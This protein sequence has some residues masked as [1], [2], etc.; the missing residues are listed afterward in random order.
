M[1]TKFTKFAAAAMAVVMAFA[2]AACGGGSNGGGSSEGGDNVLKLGGVGP[3]TGPAALYGQAVEKG[4]KLAVEEINAANPDGVQLSFDMQDDEH[5]AEKAINAYNKLVDDGMQ[6]L[7][8]TVT[9]TPCT[10]V[11]TEADANRTFALTPSASAPDVTEGHDNVFQLC[12]SD[13]NQGVASAQY[14]LGNF[15]DA[16]VGVIYNNSD[17]Y[18]SGIFS[19]FKAEYKNAI[20]E[21]TFTSDSATDFTAQLST[22]KNA[23]VDLVFLPIYYTEASIILD[24]AKKMDY[25][26]KF[27]GCDGMDGIL[28]LEGFDTSLAEGLMLLTPYTPYSEDAKSKAFTEA[29]QAAY[30]E[31]PIQ[32]A[33]DAY[34]CVYAI[35]EAFGK[36]GL[37]TSASMEE[38]CEALIGVFTGDFTV[39]GVTAE[40]MKWNANGEVEKTP[41]VCEIQDGKYVEK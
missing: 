36:T 30:N 31:T 21:T 27:F 15:A 37:E 17:N 38:I 1:K 26:P 35:Y 29:Y 4:A 28:D 12:F 6:V 20:E 39:S 2:L 7:V 25:A 9:S 5:D 3:I 41:K 11:A 32:F 34:D 40:S 13:P 18:S 8:G 22:L 19:K 24:Q 10:A 33:A 14:V 23:G 16:K